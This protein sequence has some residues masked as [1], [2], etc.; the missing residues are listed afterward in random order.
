MASDPV[1]LNDKIILKKWLTVMR[2]MIDAEPVTNSEENGVTIKIVAERKEVEEM[3]GQK[4]E[5]EVTIRIAA[6]KKGAEGMIG[7]K[8][9]VEEAGE[10]TGTMIQ[11]TDVTVTVHPDMK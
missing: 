7:R 10:N 6:V 11:E 8:G 9:I 2:N 5:N 1:F 3:I 4:G